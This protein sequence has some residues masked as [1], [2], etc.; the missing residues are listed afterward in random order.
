M[1]RKFDR[2]DKKYKSVIRYTR[3][4]ENELDYRDDKLKRES[5]LLQDVSINKPIKGCKVC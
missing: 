5:Q 1:S 4:Y 3:S 2:T